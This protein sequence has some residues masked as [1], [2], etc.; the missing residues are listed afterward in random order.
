VQ[1]EH[2]VDCTLRYFQEKLFLNLIFMDPCIVDDS[3]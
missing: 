2:R 1:G 3:V